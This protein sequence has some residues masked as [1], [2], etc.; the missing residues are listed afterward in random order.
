MIQQSKRLLHDVIY[1]TYI[2]ISRAERKRKHISYLICIT[3]WD[4][5]LIFWSFLAFRHGLV[6]FYQDWVWF[7]KVVSLVKLNYWPHSS[8]KLC[9]GSKSWEWIPLND[10]FEWIEYRCFL[11]FDLSI[12]KV[13]NIWS[14]KVFSWM[15]FLKS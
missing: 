2:W 13:W 8:M 3:V 15:E 10:C 14:I 6:L 11:R 9:D 1:I 5:V 7:L 12:A 4:I